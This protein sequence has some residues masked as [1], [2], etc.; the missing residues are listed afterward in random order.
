MSNNPRI[1]LANKHIIIL[2]ANS[3]KIDTYFSIKGNIPD[4]LITAYNDA[5]NIPNVVIVRPFKDDEEFKLFDS[6]RKDCKTF[7]D[8]KNYNKFLID[9]G[10]F[11]I[12]GVVLNTRNKNL[13]EY[14]LQAIKDKKLTKLT[15]ETVLPE[16]FYSDYVHIT[17][18]VNK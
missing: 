7:E 15:S 8:L 18:S 4:Y 2:V 11:E 14:F 3:G 1:Q 13:L 17:I 6:L 12:D 16:R 5:C 9:E 10:L